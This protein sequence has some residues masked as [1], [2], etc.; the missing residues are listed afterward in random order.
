MPAVRERVV[1]RA[2]I[3]RNGSRVDRGIN[4]DARSTARRVVE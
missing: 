2:V 4:R 3:H 1:E